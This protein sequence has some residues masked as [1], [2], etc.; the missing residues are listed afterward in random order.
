[1]HKSAENVKND[2]DSMLEKAQS[3]DV[4]SMYYVACYYHN[5]IYGNINYSE[6]SKWLN[7]ILTTGQEPFCSYAHSMIADYYYRGA[8]PGEEQSYEKAYFHRELAS[9]D[10]NSKM[11]L[12][13]MRRIGSGCV[14]DFNKIESSFFSSKK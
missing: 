12:A 3:G 13:A 7:K 1:M 5:G 11:Q 10:G 8:M 2:F 14:F 4:E 9:N 6:S